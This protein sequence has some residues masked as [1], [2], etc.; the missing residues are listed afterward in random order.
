MATVEPSSLNVVQRTFLEGAKAERAKHKIPSHVRE[1]II[2]YRKQVPPVGFAE[3][4]LMILKRFGVR[5]S[6]SHACKICRVNGV[7]DETRRE[8]QESGEEQVVYIRPPFDPKKVVRCLH[9]RCK[10]YESKA[11]PGRCFA[12][13]I[14][15]GKVKVVGELEVQVELF[16]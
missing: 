16:T 7:R 6:V 2:G 4:P 10:G 8:R 5:V 14:R 12:C 9:C 13:A 1:A 15:T 3:I 11:W